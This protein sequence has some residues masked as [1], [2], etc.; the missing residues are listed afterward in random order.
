MIKLFTKDAVV[1][2]PLYGEKKAVNFYR[3]VFKDTFKSKITLL[4]IFRSH[5]KGIAAGHFRYDWVLK[6]GTPTY[7]ECVDIFRFAQDGKI[8]QV[9]IIY[10]TAKIRP[11]FEK[12][13]N[14]QSFKKVKPFF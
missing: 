4:N 1:L 14:K 2:S 5:N 9:S 7:F 12:M 11:V 10:Y 13:K 3:G 6:D 8:K